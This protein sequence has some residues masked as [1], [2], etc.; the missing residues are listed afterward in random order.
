VSKLTDGA[1]KRQPWFGKL[2]NKI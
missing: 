1:Q 2:L